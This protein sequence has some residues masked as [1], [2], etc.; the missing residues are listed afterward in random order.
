MKSEAAAIKM[1]FEAGVHNKRDLEILLSLSD[2]YIFSE[3]C[4]DV[5]DPN[6]RESTQLNTAIKYGKITALGRDHI[7]DYKRLQSSM[8]VRTYSVVLTGQT[9]WDPV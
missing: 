7:R 8:R 6:N 3:F 1:A 9:S 2:S 5:R 4:V